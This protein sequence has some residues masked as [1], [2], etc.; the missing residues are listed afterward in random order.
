MPQNDFSFWGSLVI[1]FEK[2]AVREKE[3]KETTGK[4]RTVLSS[5]ILCPEEPKSGDPDRFLPSVSLDGLR[6]NRND[7]RLKGWEFSHQEGDSLGSGN[8]LAGE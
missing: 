1:D 3:T 7:A 6:H 5:V 4:G 2:P 8:V